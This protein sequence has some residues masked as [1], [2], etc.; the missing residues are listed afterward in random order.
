MRPH[1]KSKVSLSQPLVHFSPIWRVGMQSL[2]LPA[3]RI[4]SRCRCGR[5]K[6]RPSVH[7]RRSF[8]AIVQSALELLQRADF[9]LAD[10]LA[11]HPEGGAEILQGR[12]L[13]RQE[14]CIDD[15]ALTRGQAGERVFQRRSHPVAIFHFRQQSFRA[16]RRIDQPILHFIGGVVPGHGHVQ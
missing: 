8:E 7:R 10:P 2:R 13:F 12:R 5:D 4:R 16:R 11:G 6:S 15:M 14:A 3:L 1:W 9:D